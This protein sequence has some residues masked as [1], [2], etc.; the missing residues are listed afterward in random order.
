[1]E[2]TR[3]I[4]LID[5]NEDQLFIYKKFFEKTDHN[6]II[7]SN[8]SA[9]LKTILTERIDLLIL[10]YMMPEMS[11]YEFM[12][13]LAADPQ[14]YKV[15]SIPVIMLSSLRKDQLPQNELRKM[16]VDLFLTKPFRFQELLEIIEN[17]IF[18]HKKNFHEKAQNKKRIEELEQKN[19]QLRL[20]LGNACDFSNIITISTKMRKLLETLKRYAAAKSHI[21]LVGAPGTEKELIACALHFNSNRAE[22]PFIPFHGESLPNTLIENTLFGYHDNLISDSIQLNGGLFKKAD[23]GTLFLS[24]FDKFDEHLQ[25]KIIHFLSTKYYQ[26]DNNAQQIFCNTRI[27]LGIDN[28]MAEAFEKHT[29]KN[30]FAEK[31]I[32][33]IHIPS[34]NERQDDIA[35]L[36]HQFASKYQKQKNIKFSNEAMN[37]LKH[38]N[39]PGNVA[40][41]E[42]LIRSLVESLQKSLIMPDDLPRDICEY[43]TEN[44]HLLKN[45]LP[46]KEARRKWISQFEKEYLQTLLLKCNGN[47]SKVAKYARVNRMT[48]YRLLSIYNIYHK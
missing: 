2:I 18:V 21:F 26:K 32:L 28:R 39:W 14:Y 31:K 8:G 30:M 19:Y 22:N 38:Y 41:L 13:T 44:N 37:I 34:L 15:K 11:G 16:G 47:I 27:I 6:L 12:S 29:L 25:T 36:I 20:Q 24:G 10:D 7:A 33:K 43:Q 23:N 3:N 17:I 42:T 4:L 1:M 46:L 5:D 48:I 9:G 35:P 40:E 45:N